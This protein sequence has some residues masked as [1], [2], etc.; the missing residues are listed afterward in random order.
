MEEE[1]GENLARGRRKEK[2]QMWS[3]R[4]AR[5]T[6]KSR[7]Q[8]NT[9]DRLD[10]MMSLRKKQKIGKSMMHT[11]LHVKEDDIIGKSKQNV[12]KYLFTSCAKA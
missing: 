7:K 5:K 11:I 9:K 4:P 2:K 10:I 8:I 6:K 3:K 1:T 12:K